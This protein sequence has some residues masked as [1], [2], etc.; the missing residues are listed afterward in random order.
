MELTG[1]L[2]GAIRYSEHLAEDGDAM[3]RQACL[4]GLEG[5]ISKRADR[6]YRSGRGE[7]TFVSTSPS[8]TAAAMK[9][10]I[11]ASPCPGEH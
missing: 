7:K 2:A 1:R 9:V 10:L 11:L 5:V 4:M 8:V 6:P 3:F